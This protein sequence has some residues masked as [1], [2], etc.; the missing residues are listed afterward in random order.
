MNK[1]KQVKLN[2]REL[3]LIQHSLESFAPGFYPAPALQ[4]EISTLEN[5]I[6]LIRKK[7]K[8]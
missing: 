1:L 7:V 3:Q 4:E 6:R 2:D 8:R 5:K